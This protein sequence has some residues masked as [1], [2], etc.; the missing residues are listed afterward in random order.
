MPLGTKQAPF[1]VPTVRA[2]EPMRVEVTF[3]PNR[4]NAVIEE[5]G[6]RELKQRAMISHR[7]R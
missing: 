2:D 7:A 5:L 6:D 1:G 3:Q 4:A